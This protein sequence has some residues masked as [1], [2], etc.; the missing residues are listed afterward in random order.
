MWEKQKKALWV[1]KRDPPIS[2]HGKVREA[3]DHTNEIMEKHLAGLVGFAYKYLNKQ[4]TMDIIMEPTT[5][6]QYVSFLVVRG[7]WGKVKVK[8]V[9]HVVVVCKSGRACT[10]SSHA[11]PPSS[12]PPIPCL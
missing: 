4:P 2:T 12:P 1:F 6:A 5:F 11:H 9:E 10:P 7:V 3:V 8:V